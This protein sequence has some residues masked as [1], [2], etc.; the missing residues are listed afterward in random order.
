MRIK[1]ARNIITHKQYTKSEK[2]RRK[3]RR[4]VQTVDRHHQRYDTESPHYRA[5]F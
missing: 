4:I 3:A 2:A 5:L 1:E